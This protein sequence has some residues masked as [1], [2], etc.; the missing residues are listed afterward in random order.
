M[1]LRLFRRDFS[2][3]VHLLALVVAILVPVVVL[4]GVLLHRAAQL[5]RVRLEQGLL[6]Q[7]KNASQSIERAL[8][9]DFTILRTLAT[10][11]SFDTQDW[12]TFYEQAKRALQ[13]RAYVVV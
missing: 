13:G 3:R 2:L 10:L 6:E 7:T 4:A 1:P 11:P 12:P 8:A 5:E 9:S